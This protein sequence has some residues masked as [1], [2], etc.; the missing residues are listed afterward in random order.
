MRGCY[1]FKV[2]CIFCRL[3][4]VSQLEN[5]I[6]FFACS[7][8]FVQIGVMVIFNSSILLC[9][10]VVA[11]PEH[12]RANQIVKEEKRTKRIQNPMR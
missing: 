1:C 12:E 4:S 5:P 8:F 10:L 3:V 7:A 11:C 2:I 9:R 6:H